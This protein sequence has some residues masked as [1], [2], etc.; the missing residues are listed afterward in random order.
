MVQVSGDGSLTVT[1]GVRDREQQSRF[2]RSLGN[3][4]LDMGGRAG[5]DGGRQEVGVRGQS[6]GTSGVSCE[7]VRVP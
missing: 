7:P 2:Q 3:R 1:G 6:R 4:P 5:T